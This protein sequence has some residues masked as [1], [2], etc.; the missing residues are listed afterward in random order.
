MM[1]EFGIAVEPWK[2]SNR[3]DIDTFEVMIQILS[4]AIKD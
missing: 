3:G 2:S 4:K 1:R